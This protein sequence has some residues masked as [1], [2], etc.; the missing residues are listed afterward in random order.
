MVEFYTVKDLQRI[1][2]LPRDKTYKLVNQVDF[3][4]IR[5]GK[6]YRIPRKSFEIFINNYMGMDYDLN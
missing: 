2:Q 1:L 5:I 3:P 4:K 6:S